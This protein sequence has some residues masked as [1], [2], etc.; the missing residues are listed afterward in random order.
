MYQD[1]KPAQ[2]EPTPMLPKKILPPATYGT[3][4]KPTPA[5]PFPPV[6]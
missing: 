2:P 5:T 3:F 1:T 6:L 4:T